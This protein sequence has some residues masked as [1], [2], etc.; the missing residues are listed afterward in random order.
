MQTLFDTYTKIKN[1]TRTEID[2]DELQRRHELTPQKIDALWV[3]ANAAE[4]KARKTWAAYRD[5]QARFQLSM[6]EAEKK[7]GHRGEAHVTLLVCSLD[8]EA[9]KAEQASDKA[10]ELRTKATLA[11]H[12]LACRRAKELF[13][14]NVDTEDVTCVAA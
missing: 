11:Q 13:Y 7:E 6:I 9:I 3:L 2:G 8:R 5:F 4:S 1:G 10:A 14:N 12:D